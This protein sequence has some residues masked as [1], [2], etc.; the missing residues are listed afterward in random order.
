MWSYGNKLNKNKKKTFVLMSDGEC[1]EGS[2]WEAA[3][4]ASHFNLN[5]LICDY[6]KIQSLK[7]VSQ[8]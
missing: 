5:N 1:D 8:L 7:K 3:L 4:F 2:V 6:N